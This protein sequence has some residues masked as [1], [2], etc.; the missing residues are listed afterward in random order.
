MKKQLKLKAI[1]LRKKG[2]SIKELK[3]KL[4]VSKGSISLWVRNIPLSENAQK[5]LKKRYTQGQL[6]AQ[7]SI[8]NKT[9]EK[10]K[11]AE[12][13]AKDVF[14]QANISQQVKIFLCAMIWWCEGNKS[15]KDS[16]VFTNSDPE[17]VKSFL[18]LFRNSFD[19]DESK[20]RILMHLHDYHNEKILKNFWSEATNVP[21][22]QFN[23]THWKK[24]DHRLKKEGYLGCIKI[25][26]N[27]VRIARKLHAVAKLFMKRYK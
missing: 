15:I 12:D 22:S 14:K 2:Y 1:E 11:I 19:I 27:D 25:Q 21:I 17:L 4:G 9:K 20:I 8:L 6:A 5:R 3:E 26:Y 18:Y 10:N 24:S 7:K 16:V 23:R 13:F